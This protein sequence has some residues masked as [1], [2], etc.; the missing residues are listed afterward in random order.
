MGK[1]QV[2]GRDMLTAD[3][4]SASTVQI[5]GKRYKRIKCGDPQDFMPDMKPGERCGD[6]GALVGHYHHWGCDIERCP[7]C[8]GQLL[9]CLC[10]DVFVEVENK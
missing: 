5:N 8:H 1:C 3:G 7:A 6:C 10:K 4:C 9:S 2:C